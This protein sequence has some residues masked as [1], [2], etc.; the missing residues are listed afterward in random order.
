MRREVWRDRGPSSLSVSL[1]TVVT[2]GQSSGR[3][4]PTEATALT[5]PLPLPRQVQPRSI[6]SPEVRELVAHE[7]LHEVP[8]RLFLLGQPSVTVSAWFRL[9]I[10]SQ[11]PPLLPCPVVS[12]T[13]RSG[14]SSSSE[15]KS[16][17]LILEIG[18]EAYRAMRILV[19]N[20][21]LHESQERVILLAHTDE[22]L[23]APL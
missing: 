5:Q 1:L 13:H 22:R 16:Y 23:A 17:P 19:A 14:H 20:T 10:I 4:R 18:K 21:L 6:I 11:L 2:A 8:Q 7:L 3:S 12:V 15:A 9:F